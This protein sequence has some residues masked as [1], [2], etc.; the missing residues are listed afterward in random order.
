MVIAII[1][2]LAAA[3]LASL[4]SAR[5][6][7]QEAAVKSQLANARAQAELYFSSTGAGT[8]GTVTEVCTTGMFA[9]TAANNGLAGLIAGV[10]AAYSA[11]TISCGSNGTTWALSATLPT[12]GT[13]CVDS[14]GNSKVGTFTPD[15]AAANVCA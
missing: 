3:A 2:I 7:G 8:Y 10:T 6:K 11:S 13:Y 9:D 4:G 14:A 15:D 12:T 5:T 1:G